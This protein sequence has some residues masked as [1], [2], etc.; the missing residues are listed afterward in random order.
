MRQRITNISLMTATLIGSVFLLSACHGRRAPE[1]KAAK[2]NKYVTEQLDLD[3]VQSAKLKAVSDEVLVVVKDL[4]KKKATDLEYILDN[5]NGELDADRLI[6]MYTK[7][8]AM[9]DEQIPI[10]V[11]KLITFHK[12]LNVDQ[13]GELEDR[14]KIATVK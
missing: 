11:N 14:L 8:R 13:R 12:S 4:N 6:E 1:Q 5:I 2:V 7:R 10:I 9:L 3:A